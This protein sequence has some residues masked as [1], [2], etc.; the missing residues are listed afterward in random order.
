MALW[1]QVYV[2]RSYSGRRLMGVELDDDAMGFLFSAQPDSKEEEEQDMRRSLLAEGGPEDAGIFSAAPEDK[3]ETGA[4]S[5]GDTGFPL[6]GYT[7]TYYPMQRSDGSA[8]YHIACAEQ[9][10]TVD[11]EGTSGATS[12]SMRDDDCKK[13]TLSEPFIMGQKSFSELYIGSNGYI[14]FDYCDRSWWPSITS[15]YRRHR[16]S[17]MFMDLNPSRGGAV[18]YK[19]VDDGLWVTFD[20]VP[21]YGRDAHTYTFQYKI[22]F[23]GRVKMTWEKYTEARKTTIVGISLGKY[24]RGWRS[25]DLLARNDAGIDCEVP[26]ELEAQIPI[27]KRAPSQE[28]YYRA[29]ATVSSAEEEDRDDD[30]A[31]LSFAEAAGNKEEA[32]EA[33]ASRYDN[34]FDLSGK[35]LVWAPLSYAAYSMLCQED[36]DMTSAALTPLSMGDDDSK[37]MSFGGATVPFF[38]VD[39]DGAYVGSNGYITFGR[40]D[41]TY[42]SHR[43]YHYR[44]PR[45]SCMFMDLNPS[46]GGSVGYV[47]MEDR[48]LVKFDGVPRYGSYRAGNVYTFQAELF[49]DGRLSCGYGAYTPNSRRTIVGV[50]AGARIPLY[51]NYFHLQNLNGGA[52]TTGCPDH[53]D[54]PGGTAIASTSPKDYDQEGLSLLSSSESDVVSNSPMCPYNAKLT[55][56]GSSSINN[57]NTS[58][59]TEITPASTPSSSAGGD[60]SSTEHDHDYTD[61]YGMTSGE[62]AGF[63]VVIIVLALGLLAMVLQVRSLNMKIE[64]MTAATIGNTNSKMQTVSGRQYSGENAL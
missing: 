37:Y 9:T 26:A 4:D 31:E 13:I 49:F 34:R 7:L 10:A 18:S 35:K 1:L 19:A 64:Q 33:M 53:W 23:D 2:S 25:V 6:D 21:R 15:H 46:R 3:D 50:S 59:N 12:L 56:V 40:G 30:E 24:P 42:Y 8:D 41:R 39:Y 62:V 48:L 38:G 45:L 29:P 11:P 63:T 27:E 52:V 47:L 17:G 58:T 60:G 43:Y 51:Y 5:T 57:G 16:I 22:F 61:E 28:F 44:Y 55:V 32:S 14:T 36:G 54:S 20:S